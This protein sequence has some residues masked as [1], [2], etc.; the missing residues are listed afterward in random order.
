MTVRG[1]RLLSYSDA[2]AIL[3]G[4]SAALAAADQA[5]GGAL[6]MAT[7][8]AS[9]AVLNL[10]Q[11]RGGVLRLGRDLTAGLRER[12]GSSER[13]ERTERIAA[14]HA[15][16]VVTAYFEAL[17]EAEIPFD[18]AEVRLTR[19]D[20]VGLAGSWDYANDL[21][22]GLVASAAPQPAP[23]LPYEQVRDEL[24]SY[25]FWLSRS[26]LRFIGGL[27]V[28][29]RLDDTQR[30]DVT[31]ALGYELSRQAVRRYEELYAQLAL[32]VPEFGFWSGQIEHQATRTGIRQALTGI[33]SALA[34]LTTVRRFT[35][36]AAALATGYQAALPRPILA[37]GD[38]PT[39]VCLPTLGEGYVD[40]DFRVRAVTEGP[41]GPAEEEWWETAPVRSDLTEYLAGALTS[42]AS[43][44]APLV[45]L[46]Q[47]GAGKSVLT[48]I[49]SAR[50]PEAGF[51]PV[52]VILREVPADADVQDQIE[53]A[54]RA[55]TGERVSWPDLIRAAEG[56]V[57]VLL[58]DGFDELLQATGVSQSDYLVRVAR[59]QQ[60]EADQGRPVL[61]L[62]TSRTAV[63]DRA[64]YPQG[65][66]ALRLEPFRA[67]QVE[68]WL[69]LWNRL[70]E[71]YLT[72]NGLRPLP[73]AVAARHRALA[74]QPLLL[75]MLA[76]YDAT[77]NALQYGAE[78]DDPLGEAEL[79]EE[80]LASF[81]VREVAKSAT[82]LPQR[83]LANRVEQE[84]QRLSLISFGMLNRHRQWITTAELEQDLT[85]LLGRP[86][87]ARTDG[88]RAPLDQAEIALGRFFF[89]Q[90]AQALRDDQRLAT[91]EF[92]HAT[93]GE[94]LA[95]RLAVQLLVGL[96]DQ[97]PALSL[98]RAGVD[99]DLLYVLL[100]YAPLSSRQMLRF[101]GARIRHLAPQ[102]R[103]RLGELLVT[104]M[105]DHRNRTEHRFAEY[106]PTVRATSSRHGVY[107]ANL[108]MLTVLVRDG[109]KASEVF[110]GDANA[111]GTWHRYVL[112]WRS[113]LT[114]P[115]WTDFAIALDLHHI[116]ND[117]RRDLD[118]FP[119]EGFLVA[120][121]VDA[122]WLYGRPPGHGDRSSRVCWSRP[123]PEQIRHKMVVSGGT[124]DAV[125]LHA[126][127][128]VFRRLGSAVTTFVGTPDGT[129][130]S[131][132]HSLTDLWLASGLGAPDSELGVL[133]ERCGTFLERYSGLDMSTR[134]CA[135]WIVL[136]Q[137]VNDAAR[138]PASVVSSVLGGLYPVELEPHAL[139]AL[140]RAAMAALESG[141]TGEDRTA[142]RSYWEAAVDSLL[143]SGAFGRV[144]NLWAQTGASQWASGWFGD[145]A[146]EVLDR[147]TDDQLRDVP[148]ETLA[149]VRGLVAA[150]PGRADR[151]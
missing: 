70:N 55:T 63:A 45:V 25:Y 112:L 41:H 71:P 84:L 121:P 116:W 24:Q 127:D 92:L 81:A 56:A 64:H 130:T 148:P 33:E 151:P 124:N 77:G 129:A 29:D 140:A 53:H 52:R 42:V 122:Y 57:P 101:V 138:L 111:A 15:V 74:S 8:G 85:A 142:L 106:R 48:K 88:F 49:L 6:S 131:V 36:A 60:R 141:A 109:V 10:F 20:Q 37:E 11:A 150:Y 128:P 13:A 61:A 108:M 105:A 119:A 16:L 89:V 103:E 87:S 18:L 34:G 40:P 110:P 43:T 17:G 144:L 98:G 58:F 1:R 14:A 86:Q 26:V 21:I 102:D 134:R 31:H 50:L 104:V 62:V 114:E 23:H 125:V 7:G 46:G 30:D 83:Q 66:V 72:A 115:E 59:F 137:L 93:F 97:R 65:A 47:P 146:R 67:R 82:A 4:D 132:A 95:A 96:L 68:R 117:G 94:Y 91:Y 2:V 136:G 51:L 35:H 147:M 54:V 145:A 12:L 107:G 126:V 135:T 78:N 27:A 120:E 73:A 28:W 90:K 76:L 44:T 9:D 79:Y 139:E 113:A 5:L 75:L 100:S 39:G 99:D 32:E 149:R 143:G 22:Q 38:A 19:R 133:Y 123:Y 118:I 80:L 69:D 3:G